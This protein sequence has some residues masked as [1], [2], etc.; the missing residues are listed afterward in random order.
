MRLFKRNY[1]RMIIFIFIICSI[2]ILINNTT[3]TQYGR[4]WSNY[5]YALPFGMFWATYKN[6]I[7][8]VIQNN[9]Y[10]YLLLA[11]V[12]FIGV[13]YIKPID[14]NITRGILFP[15]LVMI[16][17]MKIKIDNSLLQYLG[18][19]SYEIYLFHGIFVNILLCKPEI[20]LYKNGFIYVT[21]SLITTLITAVLFSK[22]HSFIKNRIK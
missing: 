18:S 14:C 11:V 6:K 3:F 7:D 16:V 12:L 4:W 22:L 1:R 5:T 19:V 9:Y 10:I 8:K 17:L 2:W 13:Q 21:L 15:L 20:V